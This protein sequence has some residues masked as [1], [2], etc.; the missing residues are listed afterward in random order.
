[1]FQYRICFVN[2][3]SVGS[4]SFPAVQLL[5]FNS[6]KPPVYYLHIDMW[7]QSNK[8]LNLNLLE[9]FFV[10]LR[11]DGC[12]FIAER[13]HMYSLIYGW[14]QS[15]NGKECE[16]QRHTDGMRNA[17][18]NFIMV[19]LTDWILLVVIR[20]FIRNFID[21]INVYVWK[22]EFPWHNTQWNFIETL[23]LF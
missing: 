8:N 17:N 20:M 14:N 12:W 21:F 23:L 1:M 4:F 16:W 15:M 11:I 6:N 5:R 19:Q 7:P 13:W 22:L 9:R 2:S 10:W 18:S 3:C